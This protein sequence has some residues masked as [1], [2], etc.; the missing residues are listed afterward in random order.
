[1]LS[2]NL[3]FD[4]STWVIRLWSAVYPKG[5]SNAIILHKG[6]ESTP[7]VSDQSPTKGTDHHRNASNKM[8]QLQNIQWNNLHS[9]FFKIFRRVFTFAQSRKLKQ[10]WTLKWSIDN[11]GFYVESCKIFMITVHDGMNWHSINNAKFALSQASPFP[12]H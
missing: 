10:T 12:F 9:L 4:F 7:I 2:I 5:L 1:M 11:N 8:Q 3:E 6:L